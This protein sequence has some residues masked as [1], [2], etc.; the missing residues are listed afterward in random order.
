[1]DSKTEGGITAV[2]GII[3]LLLSPVWGPDHIGGIQLSVVG[4]VI[5]IA[6]GL[7]RIIASMVEEE[8]GKPEA[9]VVRRAKV[10][11]RGALFF[12][13]GAGFLVMYLVYSQIDPMKAA[14]TGILGAVSLLVGAGHAAIVYRE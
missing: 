9:E 14:L 10:M 6:V 7:L 11:Y 2:I 5:I 3:V 4:G 12:A 8:T 1:M 13:M